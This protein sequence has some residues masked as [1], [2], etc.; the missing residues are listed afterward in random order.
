MGEQFMG[1]VGGGEVFYEDGV[2]RGVVLG[3]EDGVGFVAQQ[4][5]GVGALVLVDGLHVRV[6]L[7]RK[8]LCYEVGRGDGEFDRPRRMRNTEERLM[9][10]E[11]VN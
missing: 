4:D 10:V 3:V 5:L 8:I 1:E 11:F 2:T 6:L 9:F 7:D